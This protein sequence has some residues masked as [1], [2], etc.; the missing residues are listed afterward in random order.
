MVVVLALLGAAIATAQ[1]R[2]P[3]GYSVMLRSVEAADLGVTHPVGLSYSPRSGVFMAI[4]RSGT[5][6]GGTEIA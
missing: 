6:A 1:S 5:S 4:G 2:T 3:E